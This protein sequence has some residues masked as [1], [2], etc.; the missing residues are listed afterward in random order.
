MAHRHTAVR[1]G[2]LAAALALF[3]GCADPV[4]TPGAAIP[5]GPASGARI[6][7]QSTELRTVQPTDLHEVARYVVRPSVSDYWIKQWIGPEGGT[8]SYMGFR[9]VVPPGA[10]DRVVMFSI[11]IPG[12]QD[13][14]KEYA[15]AEF[16][17]HNYD[18]LVPVRIELPYANTEVF[19][20]ASGVLWYDERAKVW[21]PLAGSGVTAD[22]QRVYVDTPHFS[23]YGTQ[24]EPT[25][26]TSGG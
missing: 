24:G 16:G 14:G 19:G 15:L 11:R 9:I 13:E 5:E 12:E 22:G 8:V 2:L 21:V 10:V 1:A 23:I 26:T 6:R 25:P 18:F 20:D 3:A 4:T 17:P 7:T